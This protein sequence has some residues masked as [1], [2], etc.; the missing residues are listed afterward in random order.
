METSRKTKF[1]QEK[2]SEVLT[3]VGS[4]GGQSIQ[5]SWCLSAVICGP[6]VCSTRGGHKRAISTLITGVMASCEPVPLTSSHLSSL[7]GDF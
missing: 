7:C 4:Y 1:I 5:G 3:F 2:K 6:C